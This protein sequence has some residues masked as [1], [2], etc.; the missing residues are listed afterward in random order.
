MKF[1]RLLLSTD[2]KRVIL[3]FFTGIGTGA[4]NAGI[5]ALINMTIANSQSNKIILG[6]SFVG[7]CVLLLFSM[8]FSQILLNHLVQGITYNLKLMLN[9][10]ILACPLN[11][12]E[13]IGAARL[14]ATLTDDVEAISSASLIFSN[15]CV[16]VAMTLACMIYL[17]WL[18]LSIFILIFSC[19]IL[20]FISTNF[21]LSRARYFL[22]QAR[23]E[24]D[25]LFHNFRTTIEGIKELKLHTQRRQE[26]LYEDL[27]KNADAYRQKR[28]IAG[29]II[30]IAGSWGLTALFI[31][32]GLLVFVLP[33]FFELSPSLTSAYALTILFML[34]PLR[35]I[36]N[37]LP[38]LARANIALEN[39]ESLGLSLAAATVEPEIETNYNIKLF[40]SSLELQQVTHTYI[41]ER[42]A[43]K[44][45]L[46]PI[47]LSFTVGELVFI[48]GGNGSGKSTLAK[49]ITGLYIP[50]NGTI[51]LDK[52][53]ITDKNREWYRQQF[54][55]IFAD[56][57][58]FEKLLGFQDSNLDTQIQDYLVKLQLDHKVQIKDG[59]FSTTS[60]SQG[61]R[62]RLA[63]LTAYLE[64]R[65]IYI[66]DEW[67]SD[68]DP[69]FKEIF[70]TQLLPELKERGKMVLVISHD[71]KYFHIADR[72]V[73]LDYGK[74]ESDKRLL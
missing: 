68:Q 27:E 73:K 5:I 15:L 2:K 59:Y 25:K 42:D 53:N 65:P 17:C 35:I 70:Y 66:F 24:Q 61:Q 49:L 50:E 32:I 4:A 45:T 18:S 56:F 6:S 62:K 51:K 20:G 3:A 63:L 23:T 54:S 72:I 7:F 40:K 38:E 21:F 11:R 47:D 60:L 36:L 13:Q 43:S 22:K 28:E 41:N 39:I 55:A 34:T 9:Q 19:I 29:D 1:I 64:N 52:E 44:F 30:A 31:P 67:A 14:L 58:L 57:Y 48:I 37:T 33:N 10:R 71:D 26:F 12:V 74:I 69:V 16:A 46:G 8:T